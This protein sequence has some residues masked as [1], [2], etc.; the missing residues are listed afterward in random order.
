MHCR[1]F[2]PAPLTRRQML[3]QCANGFGAVALTRALANTGVL[4][5]F[6]A[7]S[8]ILSH[9]GGA[10]PYLIGRFDVMILKPLSQ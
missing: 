1:R 9:G 6:P 7:L 2:H 5:R 3:L 8:L 10:L 4:D